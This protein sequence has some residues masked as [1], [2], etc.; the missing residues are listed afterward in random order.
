MTAASIVPNPSLG[1]PVLPP[2]PWGYGYGY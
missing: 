2:V 1:V